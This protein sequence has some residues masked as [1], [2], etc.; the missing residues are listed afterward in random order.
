MVVFSVEVGDAVCHINTQYILLPLPS[1]IVEIEV[2]TRAVGLRVV[3]VGVPS[4]TTQPVVL[5]IVLFRTIF[6]A[7]DYFWTLA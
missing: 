7:R 2:S 6:T 5:P 1:S 3:E 4:R